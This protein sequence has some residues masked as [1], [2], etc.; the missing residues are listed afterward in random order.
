MLSESPSKTFAQSYFASFVI[1][2]LKEMR[3]LPKIEQQKMN[4]AYLFM[5]NSDSYD[6][7]P[8]LHT[9]ISND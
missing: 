1:G 5:Y 4:A 8:Y 3:E 6:M 9:E 2:L 7:P